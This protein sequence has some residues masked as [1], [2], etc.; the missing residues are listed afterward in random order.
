MP[1]RFFRHARESGHPELAPGLNRGATDA[2]P[3][4]LGPRFRGGDGEE[5]IAVSYLVRTARDRQRDSELCA[6]GYRVIRIWTTMSLRMV[7]GVLQTLL[8][9]LEKPPLTPALSPQAGRGR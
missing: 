4:A 7:G 2:A 6:L 1:T 8:S 3:E 5:T 9:E